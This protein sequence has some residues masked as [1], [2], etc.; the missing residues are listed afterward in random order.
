MLTEDPDSHMYKRIFSEFNASVFGTAPTLKDDLIINDGN[1][2]SEVKRFKRDTHADSP[3]EDIADVG[4][5]N[6]PSVLSSLTPPLQSEHHVSVSVTSHISHTVT[7]SSQV[8][9]VVNSIVTLPLEQE[10]VESSPIQTTPPVQMLTRP[11][12]TKKKGTKSSKSAAKTPDPNTDEVVPAT[13]S[14]R[15]VTT[16]QTDT[17][18]AEPT[19]GRTLRNRS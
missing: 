2:D 3:V 13:W 10:S 7:G 5:D 11:R 6:A 15:A 14:R 19:T 8:S 9:N 16:K 1:Y 17:T 12:P 4:T 18:L